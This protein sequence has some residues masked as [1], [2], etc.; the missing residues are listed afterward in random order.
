[1]Y[2]LV[3]SLI[4]NVSIV[5]RFQ[6]VGIFVIS[7]LSACFELVSI[8]LVIPFISFLTNTDTVISKLNNPQ[9]HKIFDLLNFEDESLNIIIT[10]GYITGIKEWE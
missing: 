7:S 2:K 9:I 8:G 10:I 5:R 3:R 1:M 6:F 4:V